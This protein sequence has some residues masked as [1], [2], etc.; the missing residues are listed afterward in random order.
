M[1]VKTISEKISE[2]NEM[3][4]V[5]D[6]NDEIAME[7]KFEEFYWQVRRAMA[8]PANNIAKLLDD[9]KYQ[10]TAVDPRW[11]KLRGKALTEELW[12]EPCPDKDP[13]CPT[14]IA[15]DLFKKTGEAPTLAEVNETNSVEHDDIA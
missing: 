5:R 13:E 3:K 14:C 6:L 1:G 12:G 15:W 10:L 2:S 8:R 4:L 7:R 11:P 9:I